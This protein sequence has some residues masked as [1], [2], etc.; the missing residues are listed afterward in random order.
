MSPEDHV[1]KFGRTKPDLSSVD[2]AK[3]IADRVELMGKFKGEVMVTSEADAVLVKFEEF[4]NQKVRE[5]EGTPKA[6]LDP[7]FARLG[8]MAIKVAMVYAAGQRL[9]PVI[10]VDDMK[11]ATAFCSWVAKSMEFFFDQIKP[12]EGNRELRFRTQV[13]DAARG[14]SK[15]CN[16]RDIIIPHKMLLQFSHM[17]AE[18]FH[19]A[20]DS[21][22]EE[23][24]LV[25]GPLGRR[26]GKTYLLNEVTVKV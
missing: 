16:D 14:I 18:Q 5:V 17:D 12:D 23:G 15:K 22:V 19:R 26:G 7:F 1:N 13:L 24:R 2:L 4:L 25:R 8:A 3:E 9:P 10:E 20:V 11:Y 6:A 21:L